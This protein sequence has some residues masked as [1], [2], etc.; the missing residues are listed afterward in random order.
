MLDKRT[1]SYCLLVSMRLTSEGSAPSTLFVS[2]PH[3]AQLGL[4]MSPSKQFSWHKL[5]VTRQTWFSIPQSLLPILIT[6]PLSLPRA[7]SPLSNIM[8]STH[9][10]IGA[11]T[12]QRP[13]CPMSA[14]S[15]SASAGWTAAS[16]SLWS[17]NLLILFIVS[18]SQAHHTFLS[19]SGSLERDHVAKD[20]EGPMPV[21]KSLEI[22]FRFSSLFHSSYLE[23]FPHSKFSILLNL[24]PLG[25]WT[26][27]WFQ[28]WGRNRP[29]YYTG[30]PP[31]PFPSPPM[32]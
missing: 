21:G 10:H 17:L 30:L 12:H 9:N 16:T 5:A 24:L 6:L 3:T 4:E 32:W 23:Y 19:T 7:T 27:P 15:C 20:S 31:V 18:E 14:P 25:S 13:H 1:S 28:H 26:Q 8:D 11:P 22:T 29:T 2:L